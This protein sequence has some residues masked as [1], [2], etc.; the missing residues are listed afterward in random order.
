MN[1][2]TVLLFDGTVKCNRE[3]VLYCNYFSAVS[4][5]AQ[6]YLE[7]LFFSY[8]MVKGARDWMQFG[9]HPAQYI[10]ENE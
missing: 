2:N 8:D 6:S 9:L 5:T 3:W 1:N 7:I 10:M 4:K